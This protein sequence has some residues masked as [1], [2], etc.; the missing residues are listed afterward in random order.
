MEGYF[1]LELQGLV[2]VKCERTTYIRAM[3]FHRDS[4]PVF[5]DPLSLHRNIS[6]P[7]QGRSSSLSDCSS[8]AA[9]GSV[10]VK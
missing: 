4:A 6:I 7:S 1:R 9:M 10:N 3:S 2:H 8:A 5:P